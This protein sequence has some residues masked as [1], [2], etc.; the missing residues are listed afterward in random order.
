MLW[1][2]VDYEELVSKKSGFVNC[3]EKKPS[4]HCSAS[5]LRLVRC[6]FANSLIDER[7][8]EQECYMRLLLLYYSFTL[9]Q[10]FW[11]NENKLMRLQGQ[12]LD[13]TVQC[14]CVHSECNVTTFS[15]ESTCRVKNEWVTC[16]KERKEQKSNEL[17][18]H[19]LDATVQCSCV[20]FECTLLCFPQKVPIEWWVNESFV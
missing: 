7:V 13:A 12:L 16:V 15:T 17:Q 5:A 2:K 18:D 10:F 19:M 6:V 8:K 14:N 9:Y 11:E 20:R 4:V 3:F 1:A